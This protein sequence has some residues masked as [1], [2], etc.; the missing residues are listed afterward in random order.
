MNTNPTPALRPRAR[1][2]FLRARPHST[3]HT[4]KNALTGLLTLVT[5]VLLI[6]GIVFLQTATSNYSYPDNTRKYA[7]IGGI[8][9]V[10][11]SVGLLVFAFI[12]SR[13]SD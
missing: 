13:K 12:M 5:L 9:C 7:L 8:T 3:T 10:V 6:A 1:R 11:L 4:M 2:D